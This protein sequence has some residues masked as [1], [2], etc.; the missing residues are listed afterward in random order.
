MT[1]TKDEWVRLSDGSLCL[2]SHYRVPKPGDATIAAH[3]MKSRAA[4]QPADPFKPFREGPLVESALRLCVAVGDG[5]RAHLRKVDEARTLC[6]RPTVPAK[7]EATE[8]MGAGGKRGCSSCRKK[9]G[10]MGAS[11]AARAGQV[12]VRGMRVRD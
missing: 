2:A 7:D 8:T 5:K 11:A 12:V 10:P 1:K 9:A 4:V 3:E 6:A